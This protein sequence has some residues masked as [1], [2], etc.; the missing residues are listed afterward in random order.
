LSN[1]AFLSLER[2]GRFGRLPDSLANLT[3]LRVFQVDGNDLSGTLPTF[4]GL[5]P[6]LRVLDFD[7]NRFYGTLPTEWSNLTDLITFDVSENQLN[8]TI[9][10]Y[11]L[12]FKGM[13]Y[14]EVDSNF[15]HGQLPL[16]FVGGFPRLE[17]LDISN[18]ML[19]GL[20]S[21]NGSQFVNV[22][23]LNANNNQFTGPI[24][25]DFNLMKKLQYF[26]I[27]ENK[28][29]GS[30]D[31]S[32]G[33]LKTLKSFIINDNYVFGSIPSTIGRLTG[34]EVFVASSNCLTGTLPPSLGNLSNLVSII[35][36]GNNLKGTADVFSPSQL[37]LEIVDIADNGLTG[38]LPLSLFNHSRLIT[39]SASKN[40]FRG[41]I[42]SEVCYL[43]PNLEQLVIDGMTYGGNCAEGFFYPLN[44]I[45]RRVTGTIPDCLFT[46]PQLR[47]LYASGN[48]IRG[49]VGEIPSHSKLEKVKL[50]WNELS[51]TLPRSVQQHRFVEFDVS[52]NKITGV[53]DDFEN[54]SRVEPGDILKLNNNRLSG[55]IPRVFYRFD[56]INVLEGNLL[57]CT[58]QEDLPSNDPN[59]MHYICGSQAVNG[60]LYV[61]LV[62][63][64]VALAAIVAGHAA[65]RSS[66]TSGIRSSV[67]IWL[68]SIKN[69]IHTTILGLLEVVD[70]TSLKPGMS[71]LFPRVIIY[72][73]TYSLIRG[74]ILRLTALIIF[75]FLPLY[76][77]VSFI[78]KFTKSS[79]FYVIYENQYV[80]GIVLL[81]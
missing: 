26:S 61:W 69:S 18:N 78:S 76:S 13:E 45:S 81:R 17:Y 73:R 31:A 29:T 48:G 75:V 27:A 72:Y 66:G 10:S 49:N 56:E 46:M 14:F 2:T 4:L 65:L 9:P 40:C 32:I 34:L 23:V 42:S 20:L 39:I 15:F 68:V 16:D 71:A 77:F 74:V 79:Y 12:K 60:A 38:S 51:G 62:S 37:R 1:L 33:E 67:A 54:R 70:L 6:F 3:Q 22:E 19:T 63:F 35:L 53:L 30:I 50:S 52:K 43:A 57:D 64:L 24:P 44:F 28:L 41:E 25:S 59:Q 36:E 11:F 21:F 55:N 80:S 7:A 5:C 47:V 58:F 8:G